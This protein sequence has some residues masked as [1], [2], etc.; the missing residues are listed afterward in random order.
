[1]TGG[2]CAS[3]TKQFLGAEALA[4]PPVKSRRE[5]QAVA[6]QLT[7]KRIDDLDVLRKW[8]TVLVAPGASLGGARPKANFTEQDGSLWIGKFPARD[9]DRD[10]GAWELVVHNLAGQAGR[11]GASLVIPVVAQILDAP[12]HL[13]WIGLGQRQELW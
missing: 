6:T 9:D 3:T 4:A 2:R 7:S 8:L 5:L 1:M 11:G 12:L 13:R 10:I